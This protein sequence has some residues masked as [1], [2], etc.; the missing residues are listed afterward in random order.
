MPKANPKSKFATREEWLLAGLELIKPIFSAAGS[1]VPDKIRVSCGFPSR[2]ALANRRRAIGECWADKA[3]KGKYFEIFISPLLEKPFDALDTLA[4]EMVHAT[5]GLAAGHKA[6]FKKLALAIGLDKGKMP[7][8]GAGPELEEKLEAI[9]KKL[10]PY[11]HDELSKMTTA[12]KP[13]D[14]CRLLK[15]ECPKC[16]CIIRITKK[17]IESPGLPT[18]ACGGEFASEQ[19]DEMSEGDADE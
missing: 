11:P 5:V 6:P 13:K 2:N 3:S 8:A 18:C 14:T 17:C 15:A 19:Y 4:H 9:A 7:E 12:K 10:G 16:G 1:K